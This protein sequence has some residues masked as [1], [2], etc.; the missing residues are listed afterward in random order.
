MFHGQNKREKIRVYLF[1]LSF[2]FKLVL[3]LEV[4]SISKKLKFDVFSDYFKQ[5]L[6]SGKF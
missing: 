3:E 1:K 5:R 4:S 6:S 2:F